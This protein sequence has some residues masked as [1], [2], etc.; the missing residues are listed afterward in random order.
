MRYPLA[1]GANSRIHPKLIG[2]DHLLLP[3]ENLKVELA[4]GIYATNEERIPG[5]PKI[6]EEICEAVL[7]Y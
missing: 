6:R 2:S 5:Q 3:D 4:Q 1:R 7:Q